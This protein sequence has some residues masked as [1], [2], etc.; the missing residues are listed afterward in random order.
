MKTLN[1]N[2]QITGT[3]ISRAQA[4]F[5]KATLKFF[6]VICIPAL[7]N[8]GQPAPA[9]AVQ[10][11]AGGNNINEGKLKQAALEK[12]VGVYTGVAIKK[13][14]LKKKDP[15]TLSIDRFLTI[16]GLG[17]FNDFSEDLPGNLSKNV[18]HSIYVCDGYCI[19]SA[20]RSE[21]CDGYLHRFK[22]GKCQ[23][24]NPWRLHFT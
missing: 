19:V 21:T 22:L 13:D 4:I 16:K 12:I 1:D 15:I 2:S 23:G 11:Y 17:F 18:D 24:R 20:S 5:K 3:H 7:I 8:C 10:T 6:L 9:P 14:S